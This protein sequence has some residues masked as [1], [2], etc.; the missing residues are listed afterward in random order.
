[1]SAAV[2]L[3]LLLSAVG[4]AHAGW[5][6]KRS[7]LEL[8]LGMWNES[9]AGNEISLS[10]VTSSAKT[11]GFVGGLFYSYWSQE[12]FAIT[13]GA[14]VWSAEASST[15]SGRSVVQS[16]SAVVSILLGVRYYVPESTLDSPVRPYL[17][18]SVGPYM[19]FEAKNDVLSQQAR[20]ESALGARLGGGIDFRVADRI[21]L[22]VGVGYNLISDYSEPIG[23]RRNYSGPDFQFS[24]A[25][26][27]G[28]LP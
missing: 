18:A 1:M 7:S 8:N 9:K 3:S 4:A 20:S 25:F 14:G 17:S 24:I 19:G 10:G 12:N 28:D 26:L 6:N 5:L 22:G 2:L 11:N 13:I 15:V 21:K 27:F 23:A 16:S